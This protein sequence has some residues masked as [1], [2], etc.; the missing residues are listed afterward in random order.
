VYL[1]LARSGRLGRD[2]RHRRLELDLLL[3]LALGSFG[4]LRGGARKVVACVEEEQT[5]IKPNNGNYNMKVVVCVKE[6]QTNM[7]ASN[8]NYNMEHTGNRA[9]V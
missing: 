7:K 4:S 6:N 8:S 2:D 5:N 3:L 9:I 1:V